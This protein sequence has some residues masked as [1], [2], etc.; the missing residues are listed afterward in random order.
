MHLL[1]S[2]SA[3]EP[4]TLERCDEKSVTPWHSAGMLWLYPWLFSD[5]VTK[6]PFFHPEKSVAA[7]WLCQSESVHGE[8]ARAESL[9]S[10]CGSPFGDGW[11]CNPQWSATRY[12][13]AANGPKSQLCAICNWTTRHCIFSIT[14]VYFM[15]STKTDL[16]KQLT[17]GWYYQLIIILQKVAMVVLVEDKTSWLQRQTAADVKYLFFDKAILLKNWASVTQKKK[18]SLYSL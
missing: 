6:P 4:L 12:T 16:S 14:F 8:K 2:H 7:T 18:L 9:Q 10:Q 5:S 13:S 15:A 17:F 11:W 1:L 3:S